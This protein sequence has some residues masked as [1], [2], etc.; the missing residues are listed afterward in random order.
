MAQLIA[1]THYVPFD[2]VWFTE[3][4]GNLWM[5]TVRNMVLSLIAIES[6]AEDQLSSALV[7]QATEGLALGSLNGVDYQQ[8]ESRAPIDITRFD[9][10][11]EDDDPQL[12][13]LASTFENNLE[14]AVGLLTETFK[15]FEIVAGKIKTC[16][17]TTGQISGAPKQLTSTSSG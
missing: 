15:K 11:T 4:S 5:Q 3:R 16:G 6:A 10:E 12:A 13:E 17:V 8:S 14:R 2:E 7:R 9:D 1:K